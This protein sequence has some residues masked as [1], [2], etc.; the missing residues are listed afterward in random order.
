MKVSGVIPA[1]IIDEFLG[2]CRRN[3]FERMEMC[4]EQLLLRGF[5]G[6]QFVLQ[7]HDAVVIGNEHEFSDGQKA[8]IAEKIAVVDHRL[9]AGADEYLQL[10]DLGCAVTKALSGIKD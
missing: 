1:D 9:M 5:S 2:Q 10:V 4:V 8:A 3:S 7:L 6:Y